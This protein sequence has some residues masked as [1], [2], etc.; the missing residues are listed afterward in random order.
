MGIEPQ[1]IE[2]HGQSAHHQPLA[3]DAVQHQ[4]VGPGQGVHEA[5]EPVLVHGLDHL[6]QFTERPGT[7][8]GDIHSHPLASILESAAKISSTA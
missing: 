1:M 6:A 4:P 5:H 2:P 8:P 7:K 3:P